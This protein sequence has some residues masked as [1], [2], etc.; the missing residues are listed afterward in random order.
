[1]VAAPAALRAACAPL[2]LSTA[3]L[4]STVVLADP[5]AGRVLRR[6]A[7]RPDPRSIERVGQTAIVAHIATGELTLL[8][9]LAVRD[10][11]SGFGEPRYTAASPDGRYAYVTDSGR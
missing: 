4:D 11:L 7:T 9:D 8:L 2:A 1:M 5:Y 6:I 10:V 3:D